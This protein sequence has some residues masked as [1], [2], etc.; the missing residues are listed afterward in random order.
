MGGSAFDAQGHGNPQH[1]KEGKECL[2]GR[3]HTDSRALGDAKGRG[4]KS[5]GGVKH[6]PVY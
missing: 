1:C 4:S 6:T 3:C 2:Y 5:R